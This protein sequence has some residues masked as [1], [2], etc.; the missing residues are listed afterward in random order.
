LP[1]PTAVAAGEPAATLAMNRR[2]ETH[3]VLGIHALVA[4][5]F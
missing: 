3:S 1:W 2:V 4:A 5:H